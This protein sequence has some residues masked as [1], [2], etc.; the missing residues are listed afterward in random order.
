MTHPD[1]KAQPESNPEVVPGYPEPATE[2]VTLRD[3][4]EAAGVSVSALRKWY[5]AGDL[6]SRMEPGPTGPRR[7]VPLAAVLERVGRTAEAPPRTGPVPEGMA[8]VPLAV[9]ERLA[10]LLDIATAYG[11]AGERVGR[12]EERAEQYRARIEEARL[13]VEALEAELRSE[14]SRL[15]F[16]RVRPPR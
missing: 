9:A 10:A 16:R 2:W 12:A 5:R 4:A 11:E 8:L 3:A 14:R 15:R 13:R 7:M 1:P 6:P